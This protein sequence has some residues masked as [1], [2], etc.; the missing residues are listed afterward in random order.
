VACVYG[1]DKISWRLLRFNPGADLI[2]TTLLLKY[3]HKYLLFFLVLAVACDSNEVKPVDI[4]VHYFPLQTG[5]YQIY[6]VNETHYSEVKN[7][8]TL[9]YQLKVEAVDSFPNTDGTYTYV[10]NRSKRASET[11]T[12]QAVDTWSVQG[13]DRELVVSEGNTPFVKLVF[14]V[15]KGIVWNGNKFN[16]R[17]KDDYTI[18]A[19]DESFA[20]SG[21]TFDKTLT[22][23]QEDNEDFIV[24]LDKRE[25][26]YA[27]NVG[28]IYKETTQLNYCTRDNC[29][30]QQIIESGVVYKQEIIQYGTQ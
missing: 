19:L 15:K 8:E 28:L 27:R 29:T 9:V 20:A 14:P 26:V 2:K 6:A 18:T 10:F 21:I 23:V 13:S 30:G 3:L 12:W 11:A 7:P 24:S 1:K 16:T 5:D 22:V 4:G 17:A 25:E